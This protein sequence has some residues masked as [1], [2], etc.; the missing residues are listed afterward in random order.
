MSSA[1]VFR[2]PAGQKVG[3]L[4]LIALMFPVFALVLAGIL[5]IPVLIA[6]LG[7]ELASEALLRPAFYG[8]LGLAVLL[9]LLISSRRLL[10]QLAIE[11]NWV[12]VGVGILQRR[13]HRNQVR[14]IRLGEG[15]LGPRRAA[16]RKDGA[17]PV[18]LK[19][20]GFALSR[21]W[22]RPDDAKA[23]FDALR[24]H[25]SG[26]AGI[27]EGGK[28]YLPTDQAK[29]AAGRMT[30][31]GVLAKGGVIS[32]VIGAALIFIASSV[33]LDALLDGGGW[34][35]GDTADLIE[36]LGG[37]FGLVGAGWVSLRRAKHHWQRS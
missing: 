9:T 7:F 1:R 30:L 32:L 29:R 20:S 17:L 16:R 35:M 19:G 2:A 37:G 14:L 22:L 11:G 12:L 23:C 3:D 5:M 18:T 25:C 33:V 31:A 34:D 10:W 13:I 21:I 8:C 26:A 27:G 4:L 24:A 6:I 28:E 36:V 15:E